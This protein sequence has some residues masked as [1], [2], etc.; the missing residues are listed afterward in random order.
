[1]FLSLSG[2]TMVD[3]QIKS[4]KVWDIFVRLFPPKSREASEQLFAT[5]GDLS[6]LEMDYLK[7][8]VDAGADYILHLHPALFR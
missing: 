3:Q 2:E 5:I 4:A 7:A 8:K 6:P 1:M